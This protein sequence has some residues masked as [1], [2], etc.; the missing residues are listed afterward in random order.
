MWEAWGIVQE[1]YVG[2][3]SSEPETLTGEMIRQM[4][5]AGEKPAYPFLTE[6]EQV[7]GRP[8][9]DVPSELVDV[10]RAWMLI[11]Q[12]WPD[13]SGALLAE[14]AIKGMLDALGDTSARHLTPEAYSRAQENLTGRYEGIGAIVQIQDDQPTILAIMDGSPAQRAGLEPGDT[15]LIVNGQLV[16]DIPIGEV[17]DRVK[18]PSGTKVAL[19]IA[20]EGEEEPREINVTRASIDIP[21]VQVQLLP[22]GIG[23]IYI[24]EFRE[25]TFDEVL[26]ALERLNTTDFLALVLDLRGNPGG[27]LEAARKVT[28]QFL[29]DGL[30]MYEIDQKNNRKDWLIEEGGIATEPLP[31]AVVVNTLTASAAEA[32]A[33]AL[34]DRERATLLGAE[35]F[36]KGSAS[37]YQVLSDGSALYLPVAKWFTPNGRLFQGKGLRPDIEVVITAEDR[38]FGRDSQLIEAYNHLDKVLPPFR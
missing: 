33:G 2:A 3:D 15:I 29:S 9:R 22:G 19:R 12:K 4:L 36:G 34:Q 23:Y 35:T 14:A 31:M 32:V 6:L 25:N 5:E 16:K 8:S 13:M 11:Q 7:S 28:S 21:S 37:I 30:F 10:W 27:S 1:S 18:G 20:R 17:V 24:A 26:D 38:S